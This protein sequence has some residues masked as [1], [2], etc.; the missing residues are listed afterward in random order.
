MAKKVENGTS[1]IKEPMAKAKRPKPGNLS[2]LKPK[3]ISIQKY[4][5]LHVSELHLYHKSYLVEQ[6]R[7]IM[8][9]KEEWK[10]EL[11]QIMEGKK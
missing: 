2:E 1:K 7:G 9:T 6:F 8:K 10:E 5:Q 4:L 11:K 3:R